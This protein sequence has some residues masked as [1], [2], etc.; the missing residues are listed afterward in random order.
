MQNAPAVQH[1]T[2]IALLAN[3]LRWMLMRAADAAGDAQHCRDAQDCTRVGD[4]LCSQ[5]GN[6]GDAEQ[7]RDADAHYRRVGDALFT[8]IEVKK[9]TPE[10]HRHEQKQE[11]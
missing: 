4:A 11:M 10:A 3:E 2:A 6:Y 8:L 7:C 9:K 5:S 1:A